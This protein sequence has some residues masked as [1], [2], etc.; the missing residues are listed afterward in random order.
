MDEFP[1]LTNWG[2]VNKNG[3]TDEM[4]WATIRQEEVN[5]QLNDSNKSDISVIDIIPH[6][7]NL[8]VESLW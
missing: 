7:W 4:V 1:A 8:E 6:Y 5:D 2:N 3:T